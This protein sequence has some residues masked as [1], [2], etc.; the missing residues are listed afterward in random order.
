[1]AGFSSV[2]T[3][4][5]MHK[6]YLMLSLLHSEVCWL[7][8]NDWT[9]SNSSILVLQIAC[10]S[11]RTLC[12]TK[13]DE[14]LMFASFRGLFTVIHNDRIVNTTQIVKMNRTKGSKHSNAVWLFHDFGYGFEDDQIILVAFWRMENSSSSDLDHI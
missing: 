6:D 11:A 5:V 10:C 8:H 9:I 4:L 2:H 1:M 14:L 7:M 3:L 13:T 12:T